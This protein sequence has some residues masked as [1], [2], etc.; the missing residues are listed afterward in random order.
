MTFSFTRFGVVAFIAVTLSA[1]ASSRS[2]DENF[3]DFSASSE[4]RGI[5]FSDRSHDY[6]DVDITIHEGRLMLTGSMLSE[7]GRAKLVENAW[8]AEGVDQVIDEI[9]ISEKTGFSQGFEDTRIDQ[10]LRA[11]LIGAD[12]ITS[13]RYKIAVSQAVVYLIGVARDREEL[14]EALYIASSIAGVEKVVNHVL[15]QTPLGAPQPTAAPA[16]QPV[17]APEPMAP[18]DLK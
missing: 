11:R 14:D 17:S 18:V 8:T 5:L 4:L 7:Q 15:V 16:A 10:V 6:G 12:G 1:C 9:I 13:S 3:T 2:I